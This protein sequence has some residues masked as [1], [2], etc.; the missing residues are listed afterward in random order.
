MNKTISDQYEKRALTW[1]QKKNYFQINTQ[2]DSEF[3]TQKMKK[4]TY[5]SSCGQQGKHRQS[6]GFSGG[7]S[8]V[9]HT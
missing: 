6:N 7:G 8:Y 3:N 4:N 1:K 2:I 5:I 9:G